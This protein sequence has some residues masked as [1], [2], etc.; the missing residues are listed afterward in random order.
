M[1]A[2]SL[3]SGIRSISDPSHNYRSIETSSGKIVGP[4]FLQDS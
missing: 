1:L 2:M 4:G 3:D